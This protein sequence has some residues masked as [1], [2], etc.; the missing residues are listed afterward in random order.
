MIEQK[1]LTIISAKF[2]IYIELHSKK[3]Y[4]YSI[5]AHAFDCTDIY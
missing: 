5:K 2:Y 1:T 3:I 4:R